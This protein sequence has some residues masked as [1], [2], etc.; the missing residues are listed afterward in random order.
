MES[1]RIAAKAESDGSL[2]LRDLS[3]TPGEQVEVTISTFP[4]VKSGDWRS[5]H[6]VITR[7]DEPFEPATPPEDWDALQSLC[8]IRTSGFGG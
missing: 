1:V 7:Y 8:S 6:G 5:L 3:F 4:I 2:V